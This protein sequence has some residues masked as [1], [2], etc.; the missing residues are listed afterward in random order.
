MPEF[1]EIE[2]LRR[3]LDDPVRAYPIAKAGPAHIAITAA[4]LLM[5]AACI[6]QCGAPVQM[7]QPAARELD[8]GIILAMRHGVKQ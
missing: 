2:A 3:E 1:P 7:S 5:T 6:G 8:L 4:L